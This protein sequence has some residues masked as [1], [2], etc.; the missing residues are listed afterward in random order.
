M[1]QPQQQQQQG[2]WGPQQALELPPSL[3]NSVACLR[4]PN[5][6][7]PGGSTDVFLLGMSHVSKKSV[8]QVCYGHTSACVPA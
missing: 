2:K 8:Q 5:S 3:R 4:V 1:Q 6:E 7:A